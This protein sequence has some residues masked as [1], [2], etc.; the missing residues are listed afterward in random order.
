MTSLIALALATAVLVLIPGPNVALIVANAIRY[1]FRSGAVTALG[2]T[3]G[4]AIQLLLVVL[5]L[6]AIVALAAGALEWIRWLGVAY[7]LYLAWRS[8]RTAPSSLARVQAR[9]PMFWKAVGLACINPKTLLFNAAFIPQFAGDGGIVE[10]S[11][12]A[13][14][15]LGVLL[16]GDIGWAWGAGKARK[17]LIRYGNWR[18]RLAGGFFA[19]AGA[20]LAA[21]NSN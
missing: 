8:W 21:T 14:V 7:L 4:V 19:L 10:T 6:T 9:P 11:A 15:F 3:V 12:A 18:N 13:I 17:W 2:T 1:G 20:G 5:G 16:L